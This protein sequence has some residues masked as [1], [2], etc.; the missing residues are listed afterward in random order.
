MILQLCKMR[1]W[2]LFVACCTTLLTLCHHLTRASSTVPIVSTRVVRCGHSLRWTPFIPRA[3]IFLIELND[4]QF[5]TLHIKQ[6]PRN[7]QH[8]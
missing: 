1:W 7:Q 4:E 5:R 3:P 6:P 8:L 2:Q